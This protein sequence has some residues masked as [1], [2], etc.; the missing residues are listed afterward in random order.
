MTTP[1]DPKLSPRLFSP[2]REAERARVGKRL[3]WALP[4]ELLILGLLV[5]FGPSA[6]DIDRKFTPYGNEGPLR[7]MPEISIEDG[8]DP[9]R[10]QARRD[11]AA[12]PPAPEYEVIPDRSRPDARDLVPEAR[13]QAQA[14]DRG[15]PS[16]AP[17]DA[18]LADPT[19]GD[20]DIDMLMPSQHAD[21]DFIIRKLV[22]PVYPAWATAEERMRPLI[23]V[24]AAFYLNER[25]EIIAV[26]VQRNEGGPAF[27]EVVRAAM[28]Q[29]EFAPRLR[30]GVPPRPRWLVVIWRFRS[31][32]SG[33]PE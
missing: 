30:D 11:A 14:S 24:E 3:L 25:A 33:L 7:I 1:R 27:A 12:P 19:E 10:R 26:M 8:V 4:V 2:T 16:D 15:Q 13:D 23:T 22:R 32:F 18:Q 6:A 29:W 28:E 5:V 21:S 20:A 9:V 17:Q 31:P